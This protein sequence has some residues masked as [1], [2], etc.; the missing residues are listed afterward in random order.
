MDMRVTLERTGGFA[1]VRMTTT[2]DTDKLPSDD[3]DQLRQLV[4]GARFFEL[5]ETIAPQKSQPD[6]FQYRVTI[7]DNSRVHTVTVSET[8]LPPSLRPLT[9]FL[10][11]QTRK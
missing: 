5:P 9:D 11:R 6:R 3:A 7:E 10:A 4:A 8:A 1:G 2:A